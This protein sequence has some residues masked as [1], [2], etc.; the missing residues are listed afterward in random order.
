AAAVVEFDEGEAALGVAA[1]AD[2]ALEPDRPADRLDP[3]RLG[4]GDLVH[5]LLPANRRREPPGVSGQPPAL[6]PGGSRRRFAYFFFFSI[7][8]QVSRSVTARLK[9]GWPGAESLST[10]K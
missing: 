1:G 2:P 3:T 6:Q 10:Q 7:L 8:A 5:K 9:T 4:H